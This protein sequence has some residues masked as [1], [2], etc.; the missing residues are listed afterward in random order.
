PD[1]INF[2]S[3]IEQDSPFLS[4]SQND[5]RWLIATMNVLSRT[6]SGM[7]GIQRATVVIHEPANAGGIGRAHLPASASVMVVTRGNQALSQPKVDAIAA[8]VAGAHANLEPQHVEVIDASGKRHRAQA[9][10]A[11]DVT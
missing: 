11:H 9:D 3:L 1:Q 4:R 8:L 10:D 6:V 2:D 7:A 5:R